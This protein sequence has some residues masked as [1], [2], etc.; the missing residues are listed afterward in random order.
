[1]EQFLLE[2][3]R[4]LRWL[5]V[6]LPC[7]NLS[8]S[9]S[10]SQAI[11]SECKTVHEWSCHSVYEG[12]FYRCSVAAF[13]KQRMALRGCEFDNHTI[14]GV[15]LYGNP[16]LREEIDACLRDPEPLAACSYC[17]G[18]S[19]P[20]LPHRQLNRHERSLGGRFGSWRKIGPCARIDSG[21]LKV[22]S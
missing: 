3:A 6:I 4:H 13:M 2:Y 18:T 11:F 10:G 17:L 16:N 22:R 20:S 12:R 19:G 7:M 9:G 21:Q 8:K 5:K 15:P 14:D 1:V